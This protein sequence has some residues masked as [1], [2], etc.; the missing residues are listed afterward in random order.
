MW[1]RQGVAM[2]I[3]PGVTVNPEDNSYGAA[4]L[5]PAARRR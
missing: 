2:K 5:T 1:G 4:E 3:A